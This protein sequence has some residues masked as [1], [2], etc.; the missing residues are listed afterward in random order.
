MVKEKQTLQS[1]VFQAGE[2]VLATAFNLNDTSSCN[3]N[4]DSALQKVIK[5]SGFKLSNTDAGKILEEVGKRHS[6]TTE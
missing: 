6:T 4:L 1:N 5:D 2:T 3:Q